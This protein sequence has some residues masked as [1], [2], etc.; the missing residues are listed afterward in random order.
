MPGI[1][2]RRLGADADAAES[3]DSVRD[4]ALGSAML[5]VWTGT[6][7]RR[8]DIAVASMST[9]WNYGPGREGALIESY[10]VDPDRERLAY[11]QELWN[12]T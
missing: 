3:S 8:A 5:T 6:A 10:G 7:D 4:L 1:H 12:A 11:Y 2:H 9:E